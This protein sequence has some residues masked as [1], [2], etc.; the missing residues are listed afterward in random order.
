MQEIYL[1]RHG[2]TLFNLYGKTQGFCDSPLTEL[3]I[4]QARQA[5]KYFEQ[6]GLRFDCAYCS[7]SE[8]A[9]DTLL[10]V[11][12]G[13]YTRLK[14]L[15]EW[16]FG[17]F[18]GGP[19]YLEPPRKPGQN[20]HYDNFVPYGGE[21]VDQVTSRINQAIQEIVDTHPSKLPLVVTHGG[22]LYCFYLRWQREGDPRP[23]FG[24]CCI[25]KYGYDQ[26]EFYLLDWIDPGK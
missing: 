19:N 12:Q 23:S 26:G 9:E 8:R 17:I 15:K 11:Y 14:A 10:E 25:L 1:M 5:R 24:N 2:Q 18:E 3:G 22:A 16:N 4:Q 6:E 20:S 21:H 13:P 7:T